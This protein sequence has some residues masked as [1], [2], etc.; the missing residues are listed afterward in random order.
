VA[1]AE[2]HGDFADDGARASDRADD[3]AVF[4]H[5]QLAGDQN[6]QRAT[7]ATLL[8][9]DLAGIDLNLRQVSHECEHFG[10]R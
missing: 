8:T 2:Q 10:H 1:R 7:I 6:P 3:L 4:G 9:Q 5:R